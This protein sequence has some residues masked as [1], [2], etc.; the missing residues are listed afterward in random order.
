MVVFSGV[1]VRGNMS[2]VF[3]RSREQINNRVRVS[4]PPLKEAD[5]CDTVNTP[6]DKSLA[7][8]SFR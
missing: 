8:V 3:I 5:I 7:K 6:T 1:S 4:P 2:T